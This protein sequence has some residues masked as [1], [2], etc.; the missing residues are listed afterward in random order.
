MIE[1]YKG[2][3]PIEYWHV[4]VKTIA[5][6]AGD[7]LAKKTELL[8][9]LERGT[10]QF[11]NVEAYRNDHRY[12]KMWMRYAELCSDALD[13]FSFLRA[14]KIGQSWALF[15]ESWAAVLEGNQNFAFAD[16]VYRE[17]LSL[18]ATPEDRLQTRYNAF[19]VRWNKY[20]PNRKTTT[21]EN[22]RLHLQ[23]LN[24]FDNPTTLPLMQSIRA[25]S[26]DSKPSFE[27]F[28][29]FGESAPASTAMNEKW[30][31]LGTQK[32]RSKENNFVVSWLKMK[33]PSIVTPAPSKPGFEVY[34]ECNDLKTSN[35]EVKIEEPKFASVASKSTSLISTKPTY[36]PPP[37]GPYKRGYDASSLWV[38]NEEL[39]FE[40]TRANSL[41]PPV[42]LELNNHDVE[43]EE[44][45]IFS[46]VLTVQ[47]S[48][49]AQQQGAFPVTKSKYAYSSPTIHTKAALKDV[50]SIFEE[51]TLNFSKISHASPS[52]SMS[53]MTLHD[54]LVKLNEPSVPSSDSH[55]LVFEDPIA[56]PIETASE[57]FSLWVESADN[58]E[59]NCIL[60]PKR[61]SVSFETALTARLDIPTQSS[62]PN[63]TI[64]NSSCV[65][66]EM[67]GEFVL[68]TN[69]PDYQKDPKYSFQIFHD[70]EA[71]QSLPSSKLHLRIKEERNS[72]SIAADFQSFNKRPSIGG[73]TT[74]L[75]TSNE[76]SFSSNSSRNVSSPQSVNGAGRRESAS[77]YEKQSLSVVDEQDSILV[78][79]P[80]DV[81]ERKSALDAINIASFPNVMDCT[82]IDC[83]ILFEDQ[84]TDLE[85]ADR[86]FRVASKFALGSTSSFAL[87]VQ[88]LMMDDLSASN[89]LMTITRPSN[90]W[91]FYMHYQMMDRF[92]NGNWNL[93]KRTFV[94]Q[95]EVL[96]FRDASCIVS[97]FSG[98]I[99]L[100]LLIAN[101]L[102]RN[103]VFPEPIALF[104]TIE[105]LRAVDTMHSNCF[106]HTNIHPT[107][108]L[109]RNEESENTM[110]WGEWNADLKNGWIG[111][112]LGLF[113]FQE[114]ID[115]SLYPPKTLFMGSPQY[116]SLVACPDMIA[117]QPWLYQQDA[118]G[119]GACIFKM[120]HGVEM[121]I[122]KD[123]NSGRMVP[124]KNIPDN[125]EKSIWTLLF[126]TLLNPMPTTETRF[127]L[128]ELKQR[129]EFYLSSNPQITKLLKVQLCQQNI[130][131]SEDDG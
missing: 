23:T 32:E 59:N 94:F 24:A 45:S 64:E 122:V 22:G 102:K 89:L 66:S 92:Q 111:K 54:K 42:V 5:D 18:H 108:L 20:Q 10:M 9:I 36:F 8:P 70:E 114:T 19:L 68:R 56:Q 34:Q 26:K 97:P 25:D 84:S 40:E 41:P 75:E 80:F 16:A 107:C 124:N 127:P 131:L 101:Y 39:S 61:Q 30:D 67:K 71:L 38:N 28:E 58:N 6:L 12:L 31:R 125:W 29:D 15:Y 63:T 76:I 98:Q 99:T 106:I 120:M 93:I 91:E 69:I 13:I 14:N 62:P 112:G 43:M 46:K 113:N 47:V 74:I 17:G 121:Q 57:N 117:N 119:I 4:Y 126:D 90:L 104:Y 73:L 44:S 35:L 100:N 3:D 53:A 130:M 128:A 103:Q 87:A 118:F 72:K 50:L 11:K 27:I 115:L 2:N 7:V 60:A 79:D 49:P 85:F 37:E 129:I 48:E 52:A 77:S 110:C 82:H 96:L 1:E 33:L 78:A 81:E 65:A 83:P 116:P 88:D 86:F 123:S 55:F 95:R 109:V 21:D 51:S 105:I